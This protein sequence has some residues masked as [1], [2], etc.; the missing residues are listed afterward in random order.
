[1]RLIITLTAV[2]LLAGCA[3]QKTMLLDRFD[4]APLSDV[5]REQATAE[6]KA[7]AE[8]A[9]LSVRPG[10]YGQGAVGDLAEMAAWQQAREHGLTACMAE[11]GIR[12]RLQDAP[13]ETASIKPQ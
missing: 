2:V 9:K 4:G 12:V 5:A 13:A 10:S 7:K 3:P 1:M 6:C 8:L 11:K